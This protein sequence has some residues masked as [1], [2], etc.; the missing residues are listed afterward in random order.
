MLEEKFED[1][2]RELVFVLLLYAAGFLALKYARRF[3]AVNVMPT[4]ILFNFSF[5]LLHRINIIVCSR[6]FIK[7]CDSVMRSCMKMNAH[8]YNLQRKGAIET[9]ECETSVQLY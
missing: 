8:V 7:G 6:P 1:R 3:N 9:E 2:P 4:L 5:L